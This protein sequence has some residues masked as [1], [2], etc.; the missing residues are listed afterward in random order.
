[1][2]KNRLLGI[3]HYA[4]LIILFGGMLQA[5]TLPM[6]IALQD[7]LS[8]QEHINLGVTYENY[9]DLKAAL[10]EYSIASKDLPVAYL[11]MGNV[12]FQQKNYKEAGNAYKK[13]IDKTNNPGAYNNLAWLYYTMDENLD[14]AE[15]LARK[16]VD[17]APQ[18][19]EFADTL[20]KIV[21]K[22]KQLSPL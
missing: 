21:Q 6:R 10:R 17:L 14:K 8:P 4:F 12:F 16:A 3:A 9:G 13:A 19:D 20:D 5:C 15:D 18:N 11:Y 7:P 22:R 2:E 1:M